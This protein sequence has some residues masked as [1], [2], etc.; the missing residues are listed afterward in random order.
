MINFASFLFVTHKRKRQLIRNYLKP[1]LFTWC[2]SELRIGPVIGDSPVGNRQIVF[3]SFA[4][5]VQTLTCSAIAKASSISMPKYLLP[6]FQSSCPREQ[7]HG[8]QIPCS[9]VI[10]RGLGATERVRSKLP[11]GSSPMLADRLVD[12]ARVLPMTLPLSG[13]PN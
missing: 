10:Q 8:S 4:R 11:N 1:L 5:V 12:E 3:V 13:Y 9:L 7:L 6:S 2:T